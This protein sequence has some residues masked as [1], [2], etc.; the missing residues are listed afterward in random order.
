M[1]RSKQNPHKKINN[2]NDNNK[3]TQQFPACSWWSGFKFSG[4]CPM[5]KLQF[6]SCFCRAI[7]DSCSVDFLKKI[8]ENANHYP[9]FFICKYKAFCKLK[10]FSR[11]F[12]PIVVSQFFFSSHVISLTFSYCFWCERYFSKIFVVGTEKPSQESIWGVKWWLIL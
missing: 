11:S 9:T 5:Q 7:F 1:K 6:C 10:F 12:P 8:I 2:S 3:K 4:W